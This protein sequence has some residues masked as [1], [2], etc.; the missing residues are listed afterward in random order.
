MTPCL[1]VHDPMLVNNIAVHQS[2]PMLDKPRLGQPSKMVLPRSCSTDNGL[3]SVGQQHVSRAQI[4]VKTTI[5]GSQCAL[6]LALS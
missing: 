4:E 6:H 3:Q 2:E 1:A 5:L